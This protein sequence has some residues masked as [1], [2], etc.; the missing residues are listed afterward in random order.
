M[1]RCGDK[2]RLVVKIE[3]ILGMAGE[4]ADIGL[5]QKIGSKLLGRAVVLFLASES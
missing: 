4:S 5:L 2:R 3:G 1:K